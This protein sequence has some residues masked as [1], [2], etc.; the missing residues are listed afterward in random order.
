MDDQEMVRAGFRLLL[1]Q[2]PDL[3]VVGEADDGPSALTKAQRLRPDVILMD[4]RMP[5]MDGIR[6][7][8]EILGQ[9]PEARVIVLTTF[10]VDDYV[11]DAMRAGASGFLLKSAP[12]E[13]L[14]RAIRTVAAGDALLDPAVTR[15]VIERF[16]SLSAAEVR[17][18]PDLALLTKR[19]CEVLTQMAKGLSNAEIAGELVV[20]E[21]TVKTHVARVLAKLRL[22]DRVQAVVYAYENGIARPGA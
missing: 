21:A 2:P 3:V 20:S 11:Y 16:G 9:L 4:V 18:S 15:R 8:R 13:T 5:R 7:T 19:E 17:P 1:E 14:V 22:R 12:A 6:T 10:D